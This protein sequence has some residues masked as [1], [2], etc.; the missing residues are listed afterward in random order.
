MRPTTTAAL[1]TVSLTAVLAGCGTSSVA[2][3][4]KGTAPSLSQASP[5]PTA[6]SPPSTVRIDDARARQ[7]ARAGVLDAAAMDG[8]RHDPGVGVYTA[9]QAKVDDRCSTLDPEQF[10]A[11][12]KAAF[13]K[14]F[15]VV[16]SEA[17]VLATPE[18]AAADFREVTG[19][20][21]QTCLRTVLRDRL[22][23]EGA[24]GA[25][26]SMKTVAIEVDGADE[27]FSYLLSIVGPDGRAVRSRMAGARV[28]NTTVMVNV[29]NLAGVQP[30]AERAVEL[31]ERAVA[32]V[33]TALSS[34]AP[35]PTV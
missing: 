14:N 6:S 24:K 22:K 1:A 30:T 21:A 31:L 8:Y 5:S 12:N 23:N 20:A 35:D 16:T 13:V 9:A 17:H 34:P 28:G 15:L 32:G 19:K 2:D 18:V 11:G 25:E 27:T 10:V 4:A 3:S 26:T 33:R 29:M 7:L